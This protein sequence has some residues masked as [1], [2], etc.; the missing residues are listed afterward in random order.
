M[1]AALDPSFSSQNTIV[2]E[3]QSGFQESFDDS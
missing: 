3:V 1:E 2:F